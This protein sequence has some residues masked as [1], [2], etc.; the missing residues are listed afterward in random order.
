MKLFQFI[1]ITK[2]MTKRAIEKKN[3]DFKDDIHYHTAVDNKL[4][5]LITRNGKDFKKANIIVNNSEEFI[6]AEIEKNAR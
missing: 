5:Y 3:K 6:R 4:D 2:E 1:D